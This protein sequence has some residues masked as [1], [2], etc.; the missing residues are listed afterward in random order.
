[1]RTLYWLTIRVEMTDLVAPVS[2]MHSHENSTRRL[3]DLCKVAN[4]QKK[5][6][7]GISA[8]AC[9]EQTTEL[10]LAPRKAGRDGEGDTL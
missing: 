9:E 5:L 10:A 8:T 4:S 1:M 6:G 7:V 2:G 3:P